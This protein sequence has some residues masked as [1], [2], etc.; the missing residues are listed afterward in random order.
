MMWSIF[1]H[2]SALKV[3]KNLHSLHTETTYTVYHK[4]NHKNLYIIDQT[5]WIIHN[6]THIT[7]LKMLIPWSKTAFF[8]VCEHTAVSAL[9]CGFN[10]WCV[11]TA[12]QEY[13]WG[14]AELPQVW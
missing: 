1:T 7:V 10:V 8:P 5:F 2:I 12:R 13:V 6:P 4:Y 9:C 14:F 11:L 3:Q